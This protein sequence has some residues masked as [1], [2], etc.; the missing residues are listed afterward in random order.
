MN[1]KSKYSTKINKL[2]GVTSDIRGYSTILA[3]FLTKLVGHGACN[4][5]IPAELFNEN[6]EFIIGL[7]DGYFSG[8]GTITSNSIQVTSASNQLI[9]GIQVL[10]NRLKIFGKLSITRIKKNNIGTVD[11]ADINVLS[12]RG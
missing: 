5:F 10:L 9:E 1:I 4:K 7:L 2:G 8:D 12:I 6:E 11:M 3:K